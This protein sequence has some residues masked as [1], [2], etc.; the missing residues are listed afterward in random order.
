MWSGECTY[1]RSS[2]RACLSVARSTIQ[3]LLGTVSPGCSSKDHRNVTCVSL[4]RS[5][6]PSKHCRR[7]KQFPFA[8]HSLHTRC[9]RLNHQHHESV[10]E[11]ASGVWPR[12]RLHQIH[13]LQ[14]PHRMKYPT[15]LRSKRRL[16]KNKLRRLPSRSHLRPRLHPHH[17]HHPFR[18]QIRKT[19]L[20]YYRMYLRPPS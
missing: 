16:S 6:L 8:Y 9:L 13:R 20:R 1:W 10:I 17:P 5:Q 14:I 12:P 18:R 2:T 3:R 19:N 15:K 7:G 4:P 11:S